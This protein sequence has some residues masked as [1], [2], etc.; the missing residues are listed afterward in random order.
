MSGQQFTPPDPILLALDTSSNVTSI[1]VARG[2]ELLGSM[3]EPA[4]EKR[5]EKLWLEVRSL[6]GGLEL[7]IRDVDV[8][9]VCIGPGGF[10]GLRVG[11]A[12]VKGMAAALS[13]PVVGITSLEAA[14]FGAGPATL[15]CAMWNAYKG[16][17]YSQVFSFDDE[18]VPVTESVAMVSTFDKALEQVAKL[19]ELVFAGEGAQAGSEFIERFASAREKGNWAIAESHDSLAASVARL[20]HLKWAGGDVESA[21]SLSACYVRPAEAEVKLALGLL[22]SKIKRSMER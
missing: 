18:G 19:D 1:A 21:A 5:S 3:S 17:V 10:T 7:T 20:A 8:F 9:S 14:A 13:K 11:V 16:E 15:V 22:G 2:A 12:A 4:D 6:L